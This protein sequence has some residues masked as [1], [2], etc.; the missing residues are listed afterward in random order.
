M[1]TKNEKSLALCLT[2]LLNQFDEIG[3]DIQEDSLEFIKG[4]LNRINSE[5]E[6]TPPSR[7]TGEDNRFYY[8]GLKVLDMSQAERDELGLC[9]VCVRQGGIV[10]LQIFWDPSLQWIMQPNADFTEFTPVCQKKLPS[11]GA[12]RILLKKLAEEEMAN[13]GSFANKYYQKRPTAFVRKV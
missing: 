9:E 11:G 6:V 10:R 3:L 12:A 1:A 5:E 2:M 7:V 4:E 13:P 8:D